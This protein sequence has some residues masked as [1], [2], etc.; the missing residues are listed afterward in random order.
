MEA[1]LTIEAR[2]D[3]CSRA[4]PSRASRTTPSRFT[5][6]TFTQ[7]A[8][9]R[10]R[11][12]PRTFSP[13]LLISTSTRPSRF[14][15]VRN[16]AVTSWPRETSA[17]MASAAA[18]RAQ[19]SPHTVSAALASTSATYTRAPSAAQACAIA[20]PMP[21]PAPV[22]T[23]MR[24]SSR[25]IGR[26][27]LARPFRRQWCPDRRLPLFAHG[28]QFISH[29]RMQRHS[30]IKIRFRGLQ[31]QGDGGHLHDLGGVRPQYMA[32]HYP[33]AGRIDEELHQHPLVA[34]R[35]RMLQGLEVR[36]IH[37][38]LGYQ[39]ARDML[40]KADGAEF[41][42][43][44]DRGR[45]ERMVHL[46]R[47][48]A[49]LSVGK[50]LPLTDRNGGKIDTV[51]YVPNRIDV[52]HRG[53]GLGVDGNLTFR[54]QAHADA[55]KPK[56]GGI[57]LAAGRKHDLRCFKDATILQSGLEAAPALVNARYFGAAD[58]VDP[59]L[60]EL[61]CQRIAQ[62]LIKAA[63]DLG[64]SIQK[65]GGHAES[66]ENRGEFDGDIT[67]PDDQHRGGEAIE[68]EGRSEERRVG[69]G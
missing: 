54:S 53:A 5:S 47:L 43:G 66:L 8:S 33:I 13:A 3:A 12:S 35:Q 59:A 24:C 23:A 31:T 40:G 37:V 14:S 65:R 15:I 67:A 60:G 34:P 61:S 57:R 68:V 52:R 6:L 7:S 25:F 17:V 45:H 56:V 10:C 30:G 42:R 69:K 1:I 62:V 63:Q 4:K 19:S 26:S 48:V 58:D 22:T 41:R 46:G 9:V 27:F 64:P 11:K 29:R 49:E 38:E 51:G 39:L 18:P 32:A 36:L 28:D 2:P 16:M 50:C 21:A 44:K 55:L 20:R